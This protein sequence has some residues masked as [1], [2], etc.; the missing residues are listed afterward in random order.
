PANNGEPKPVAGQGGGGVIP[1]PA[2]P[3]KVN[4]VA[5]DQN[6]LKYGLSSQ[7]EFAYR[8]TIT[9][10]IGNEVHR[11]S[12]MTTYKVLGRDPEIDRIFQEDDKEQLATGSG[13]VVHPDGY[14]MTC[15]HVIEG[16]TKI[17]VDLGNK[18]YAARVIAI[19][20]QRDIALIRISARNL[21]VLPL[22]NSD[23]IELAQHVRVVGYPL[24]DVLGTS[25]KITQG[26]VAGFIDRK[27]GRMIQVDASMNPG[28]S[29][30]PLVNDRGEAIGVASAGFFGSDISEVGLGVPANDVMTLMQKNGIAPQTAP[31]AAKLEGPELARKVT[32]S[33]AYLRVTMGASPKEALVLSQFSTFSTMKRS[34]NGRPLTTGLAPLPKSDS[35]K[36]LVNAY[37]EVLHSDKINNSLPYGLGALSHL[38]IELLSA[39]GES[40]WGSTRLTT[41]AQV[42]R[43][44]SRFDPFSRFGGIPRPRFGRP[45][46][47]PPTR[48]PF[49]QGTTEVTKVHLALETS[50][51]ELGET[52]PEIQV[53]DKTYD[54]KTMEDVDPPYFHLSGKGTIRF[55]R[56]RLL[57]DQIRYNLQLQIRND[58]GS[59]ARVPV[60][61]LIERFTEQELTDHNN[62]VADALK[63]N[64]EAAQ[65]RA[66]GG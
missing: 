11:T 27:N 14:L 37:G 45:R 38:P 7:K 64:Q 18:T 21:P 52:T 22:G 59:V 36:L 31:G 39:D 10:T 40:E 2:A 19:N 41:I 4:V 35:G 24:S 46:G 3:G 55:D 9:A 63:K 25:V 20:S 49:D 8:T 53:I 12:G 23:Q 1:A 54:F 48:N 28:N 13:F 65:A 42:K 6:R 16:A 17:E 50:E 33:V 51:Y 43:T 47:L 66:N 44:S 60:E 29:G 5:N 58:N 26:S 57:P 56:K 34:P 32:P 15:A 30:G 61:V 62:R